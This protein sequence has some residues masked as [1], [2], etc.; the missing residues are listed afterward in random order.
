VTAVAPDKFVRALLDRDL[1]TAKEILVDGVDV[2]HSYADTGWTAL[3]YMAENKVIESARWLLENGANPNAKDLLG[4]TP[5]HLAI[6]SEAD[7][8]RQQSV[9][10][11][12]SSLSVEMTSLLLGSGADP[13]IKTDK[14]RTA[15]AIALSGGHKLAVDLL[16]RYGTSISE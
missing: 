11:G 3:H 10:K 16:S 14:G 13:N 9:E 4:Q 8:A 15:L 12:E 7:S 5:L 2:N 1:K 6:D